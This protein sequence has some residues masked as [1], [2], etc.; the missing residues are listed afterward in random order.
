MVSIV[1][2]KQSYTATM[3]QPIIHS[4][5]ASIFTSTYFSR[6]LACTFCNDLCCQ[7]GADCED[8]TIKKLAP[9]TKAL[10]ARIGIP[11]SEW[12]SDETRVDSEFPGGTF[13]RTLVQVRDNKKR[14]VFLN[15]AGRGCHIHS[16]AHENGL[17]Y[18]LL[19]PLT[20]WLFPITFDKGS[21]LLST[22]LADQTL[23]CK[24]EGPTAYRSSRE[25]LR[26]VFGS[27]LID[28]LDLI[29][30]ATISKVT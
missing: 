30:H 12:F 15:T 21:L 5:E 24:G 7:Y 6:C 26:Y 28:E 17:D 18:H 4:V 9:Y 3:G 22:E 23:I 8:V 20:C 19:K 14:C 1:E 2:L 27:A 11:S 25:E 16:F 13:R 10:E 29:E